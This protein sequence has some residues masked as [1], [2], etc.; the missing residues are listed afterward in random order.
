[1]RLR[2]QDINGN[3]TFGRGSGN[4]FVNSAAGVAQFVETRLLLMEGEWFL[5][6]TVGTPWATEILGYG[7]QPLYD[8]AIQQV[9]L[10]TQGVSS[11]ESYSSDFDKAT[12]ALTVSMTI[13]TIYDATAVPV[14][15]TL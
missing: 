11:I 14:N 12:R 5:D 7:T 15:V 4:F 13:L 3:Y 2:M 9:V 6:Q 10:D 8:M 1:M